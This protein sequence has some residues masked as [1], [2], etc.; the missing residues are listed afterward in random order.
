MTAYFSCTEVRLHERP[1]L[2]AITAYWLARKFGQDIFKDINDAPVTFWPQ[3]SM[4]ETPAE[5][6]AKGII[7]FDVGEGRFDHHPH[8]KCT[9]QCA[10]DLVAEFLQITEDVA[11]QRILDY[12]RLHDLEGPTSTS[13]VLRENGT[14]D[15]MVTKTALLESFSLASVIANLR[16]SQKDHELIDWLCGY[17]D[18]EYGHQHRFWHDVQEE[19]H[20]KAETVN[21]NV[22]D[23]SGETKSYR[24]A[25]IESGIREVGAFSRTKQ[26]GYCHVCVH[27]DEPTGHTFISGQLRSDQFL[28]IAKI[29]RFVE[30]QKRQI[31]GSYQLVDMEASLFPLCPVWYLPKNLRGEVFIIM[32]GGEKAQEVEPSKLTL[33]EIKNA[34]IIGLDHSVFP[35]NCPKVSCL[36]IDCQLYAGGLNRCLKIRQR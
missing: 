25:L 23:K 10:T 28:E 21:V 12:V 15:E 3:Q 7:C 9:T 27:R 16:Q 33:G 19:F 36:E 13:R 5:L 18:R 30:M 34:I 2:D 35:P 11:L 20:A 24:L 4:A 32:N 1:D 26:A 29:L 17:F 6:E 31:L 14:S 8:G 22:V